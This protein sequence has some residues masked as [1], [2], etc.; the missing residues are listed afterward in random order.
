M[1][2]LLHHVLKLVA[3][4][5]QARALAEM[6]HLDRSLVHRNRVNGSQLI[7]GVDVKLMVHRQLNIESVR[8]HLVIFLRQWRTFQTDELLPL[9]VHPLYVHEPVQLVVDGD[10]RIAATTT[11]ALLVCRGIVSRTSADPGELLLELQS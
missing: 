1:H 11:L 5:H 2:G 8:L 10:R 7:D 6:V 4:V 9:L 3:L